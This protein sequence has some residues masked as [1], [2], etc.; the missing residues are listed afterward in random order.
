M[1]HSKAFVHTS[2]DKATRSHSFSMECWEDTQ[3]SSN[4]ASQCPYYSMYILNSM[5]LK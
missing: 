5:R 2:I 1:K 3:Q 4:P